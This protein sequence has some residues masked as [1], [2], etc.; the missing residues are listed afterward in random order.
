LRIYWQE[1]AVCSECQRGVVVRQR[2]GPR[3]QALVCLRACG[4]EVWG[5]GFGV[6]GLG[7]GVWGLEFGVWVLGFGIWGLGVLGFWGFGVSGF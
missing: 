2:Q 6:W 7:F 1:A 5:L 3:V 4:F